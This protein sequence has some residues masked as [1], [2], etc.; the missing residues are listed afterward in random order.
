MPQDPKEFISSDASR[1]LG[2]LSLLKT[3]PM[4]RYL[5]FFINC[6]LFSTNGDFPTPEIL[7]VLW[8]LE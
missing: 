7:P 6:K 3:Y 1:N 8:T 5:L 2:F 4:G